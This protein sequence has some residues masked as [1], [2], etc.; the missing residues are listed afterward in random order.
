MSR[1]GRNARAPQRPIAVFALD[2]AQGDR[3]GLHAH[4]FGQLVHAASGVM[5]VTTDRGAWIVPPKRA[6]WI[7][8][9]VEHDVHMITSVEMRTVYV[10]EDALPGA[11]RESCVVDVSP[12]LC[13]MILEAL[14]L[15]RPYPL[16]GAE[17]RLFRVLVDRITFRDAVPLHLPM[18]ASRSLFAI[19]R[20]LERD[21][22]DERTLAAWAK[23]C[24]SSSRTLAR[25]FRRETG[26][27]FGAWRSQL[28]LMRA[29]EMLA[30][31]RSVT[32]VALSL[33]YDST[34]A[35]INAFRRHL[36]ATPARYFDRETPS[37]RA[38]D[39]IASP[40]ILARR[41]ARRAAERDETSRGEC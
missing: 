35:F 26:I 24:G 28:R 8:P 19:A 25:A 34:S 15:P 39:A 22:S 9:N 23:T 33:G 7:P 1:N 11:P 10:V 3:T 4:P 31:R 6:V 38:R 27:S 41:K 12:L 17:E 37:E 30:L 18:P 16:G 40:A 2:F 20:A 13:E 29:L 36:G 5:R 32:E 14:R 21:P